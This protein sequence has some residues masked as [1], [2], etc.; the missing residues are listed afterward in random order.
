[1]EAIHEQAAQFLTSILDGS[2]LALS[3]QA[4]ESEEGYR[5]NIDGPDADLLFAQSGE[6]LD[7]LQH[8][9]NQAFL[10][11][12]PRGER[13]ICDANNFRATR[14]AELRAMANHAA[15]RVRSGGSPFSFGPMNANERRIIHMALADQADLSTESIG[16]GAG[17]RLRVSLKRSS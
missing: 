4:S 12:V 9:V 2:G 3:V 11:D 15:E 16:D 1:M 7:A 6:L 10:R 13:L 17:R 5:F 14:E 8:L